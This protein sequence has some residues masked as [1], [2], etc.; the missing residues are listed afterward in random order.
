M[1][2][3]SN[4]YEVNNFN[5]MKQNYL[6]LIITF[7]LLL[8]IPTSVK[9]QNVT[10]WRG[11]ERSGGYVEKELLSEWSVNGPEL[12]W[13]FDG[14]RDGYS[15]LCIVDNVIYTTGKKDS[16]DVCIALEINGEIL[17]ETE[18]G[19]A[20]KGSFPDS[21]CTPTYD[22][23]KLYLSSGYGDVACL[24]AGTGVIVWQIEGFEKWDIKF[25]TWGCAESLIVFEDKVIFNPIGNKTTTVALNKET[26]EV[27]WESESIQDSSAYVSPI[28]VEYEDKDIMVNV[29]ASNIYGVDLKTGE[30][31][32]TLK[33][34][35]I[36]TPLRNPDFPIS[37]CNSPLAQNNQIYITSGY[38]HCGLMLEL[39]NGGANIEQLWMDTIMDTHM[40]GVVKIGDYLYGSNWINNAKGNWVCL[41]WKTGAVQWEE[42]WNSKGCIIAVNDKLILYDEKR[43]NIGLAEATPEKLTLL[44]S[45]TVPL[46]KGRHWACPVV[47]K[48]VLF[49]RHNNALMAYKITN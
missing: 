5:E 26:G 3:P 1:G 18:Y 28:V 43:G 25:W 42:T 31:L 12:L 47:Y 29:S 32:W 45:F 44:S 22:E 48:G 46:G 16:M 36:H 21:R 38:D 33:Y 11:P 8:F 41:D 39:T 9:S 2:V 13:S 6:I 10:Q 49:I 7:L 30:M 27:I 17:W 14:L 19:R 34:Y 35:D 20:W 37:N 40:G 4:T 23:E 24:D 15:S